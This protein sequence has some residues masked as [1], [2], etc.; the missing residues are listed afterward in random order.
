MSKIQGDSDDLDVDENPAMDDIVA[1]I[2]RALGTA[3]VDDLH[4]L[5]EILI[6]TLFTNA[7]QNCDIKRMNELIEYVS[8]LI[9]MTK[10]SIPIYQ[11]LIPI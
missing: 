1:S 3:A 6:P 7:T 2:G 10:C 11:S 5:Q 4:H 9:N 8:L